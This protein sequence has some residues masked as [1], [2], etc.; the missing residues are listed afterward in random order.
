MFKQTRE[1]DLALFMQM[2]KAPK[3]K[4]QDDIPTTVLLLRS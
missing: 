1:K 2:T 4:V 3:P